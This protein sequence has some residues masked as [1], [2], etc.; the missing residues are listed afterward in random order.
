M[1]TDHSVFH[2]IAVQELL[3]NT[4]EAPEFRDAVRRAMT[5]R[6]RGATDERLLSE[7]QADERRRWEDLPPLV[8]RR[9]CGF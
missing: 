7:S 6:R 3:S 4:N 2:A 8:R 1:L 9:L 5:F